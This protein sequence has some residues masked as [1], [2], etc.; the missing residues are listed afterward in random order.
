MSDKSIISDEKEFFDELNSWKNRT[1]L[2]TNTCHYLENKTFVHGCVDEK[3]N[4]HMSSG[5]SF[6]FQKNGFGDGSEEWEFYD[7]KWKIVGEFLHINIYHTDCMGIKKFKNIEFI[8]KF[9]LEKKKLKFPNEK[10]VY[11]L[12][13]YDDY[14][15]LT[16]FS[17]D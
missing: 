7:F 10:V 14:I 4:V 6:S 15:T 9:K 11:V 5:P 17:T 2:N 3:K 8:Y 1:T 13:L 12:S 16:L